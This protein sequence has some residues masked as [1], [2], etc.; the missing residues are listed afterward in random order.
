MPVS[1]RGGWVGESVGVTLCVLLTV[2]L[3]LTVKVWDWVGVD[4]A[5][6]DVDGVE[7]AL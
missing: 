1:T 4:V 3:G 2:K 6:G 5:V 7:V